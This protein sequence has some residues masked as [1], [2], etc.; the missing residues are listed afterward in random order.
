MITVEKKT[1]GQA[2]Y[3]S[4]PLP[5]GAWRGKRLCHL[6]WH[7]VRHVANSHTRLESTRKKS[8]KALMLGRPKV[9][10][11]TC[12]GRERKK[13]RRSNSPLNNSEKQAGL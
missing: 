6:S 12:L 10:N 4:Q 13:E 1:P 8:N 7:E 5:R 9:L 3:K 11:K 2:T